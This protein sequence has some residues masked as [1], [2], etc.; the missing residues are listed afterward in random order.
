MKDIYWQGSNLYL[1]TFLSPQTDLNL[2][3][4]DFLTLFCQIPAQEKCYKSLC[5]KGCQ[6]IIFDIT[7]KNP[8]L[9]FPKEGFFI[10]WFL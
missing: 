10:L 3:Q 9:L 4:L 1:L 6:L 7:I 8:S 2:K 5:D